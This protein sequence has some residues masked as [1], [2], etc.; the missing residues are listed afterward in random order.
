MG[1]KEFCNGKVRNFTMALRA[2]NVSGAFEK[3]VPD[4][5]GSEEVQKVILN[6]GKYRN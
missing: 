2:R 4:P 1:I 6:N 5:K 3:Q